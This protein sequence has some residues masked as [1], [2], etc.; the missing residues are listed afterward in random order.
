MMTSVEITPLMLACQKGKSDEVKALF[1]K[2]VIL[3]YYLFFL[4]KIFIIIIFQFKQTL[5]RSKLMI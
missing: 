2:G 3:F 1:S 4:F 5:Y